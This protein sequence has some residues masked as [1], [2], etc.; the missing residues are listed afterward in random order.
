MGGAI[1]RRELLY[2]AASG[3]AAA[4]VPAAAA[5]AAGSREKRVEVVVVGGGLAGLYAA[6]RLCGKRSFVV[7]EAN[8]R[9]GGRVLNM[10]VGH[11]SDIRRLV[12]ARTAHRRFHRRPTFFARQTCHLIRLAPADSTPAFHLRVMACSGRAPILHRGAAELAAPTP[13]S[14]RPWRPEP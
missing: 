4:V 12:F 2:G 7:L 1:N 9:L 13:P 8:N 10:K 6:D 5:K 3:T 14:P 11:R